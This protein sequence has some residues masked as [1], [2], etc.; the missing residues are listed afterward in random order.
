MW[1]YGKLL[2]ALLTQKLIRIGRD[3]SPAGI[4]SRPRRS[5]SPWRECS[6]AL[7]NVQQVIEPDLSLNHVL[8][9]WNEIARAPAEETRWRLLQLQLVNRTTV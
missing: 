4:D 9:S 5:P 2:V 1:V 6:F 7:R 8:A 3:V